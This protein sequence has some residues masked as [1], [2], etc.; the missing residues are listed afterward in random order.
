MKKSFT[1]IELLVVIAIIAILAG[2]L[3]PAL[4][5]ARDRSK[6]AN[7]ISNLKQMATY[8]NMYQDN[9]DTI[10]QDSPYSYWPTCFINEGF[11]KVEHLGFARC[12]V[13]RINDKT[14]RYQV[15]GMKKTADNIFYF[16][17]ILKPSTHVAFVD[18][19]QVTDTTNLNNNYQ[20]LVVQGFDEEKSAQGYKVKDCL[21]GANKF[22]THFLHPNKRANT[23]F[24]DGHA[25]SCS[26]KDLGDPTYY[27]EK[28]C[29]AH[30]PL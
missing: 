6:S 17:K 16:K 20:F 19:I 2:M 28:Y 12:P 27:P 1:L 11:M 29:G 4:G 13:G 23:A 7:C 10:T 18:S 21:I 22:K 3:L 14:S 26:T 24:A 15:Y 9:Y 5:K 25:E 8:F 30:W